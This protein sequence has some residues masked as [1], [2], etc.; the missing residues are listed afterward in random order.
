M[1]RIRI[2]GIS[3]DHMHIGDLLRLVHENP[4][5]ELVG[6]FDPDRNRMT[7]AIAECGPEDRALGQAMAER[8]AMMAQAM[9]RD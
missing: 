4:E 1:A 8:L 9:A 2:V 7:R 3:F 6:I 5:A